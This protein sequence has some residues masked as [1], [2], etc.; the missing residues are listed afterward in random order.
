[1]KHLPGQV[2]PQSVLFLTVALTFS[3]H[4]L[5]FA[6]SCSLSLSSYLE[7]FTKSGSVICETI[8][9]HCWEGGPGMGSV[10]KAQGYSLQ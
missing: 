5:L 9:S 3:P 6:C 7:T 1:M 2:S 4:K 8:G 10:V